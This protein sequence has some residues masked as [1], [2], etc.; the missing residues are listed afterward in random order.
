MIRSR[1]GL[2]VSG[3][4]GTNLRRVGVYLTLPLAYN[5]LYELTA[6]YPSESITY[7]LPLASG[8][9]ETVQAE[10]N[11]TGLIN[12]VV[13]SPGVTLHGNSSAPAACV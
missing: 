2:V 6:V 8:L 7:Q 9:V 11:I 13:T 3:S 5:V 4:S 10:I 1:V 12:C